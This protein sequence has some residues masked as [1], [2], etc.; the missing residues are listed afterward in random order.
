MGESWTGKF[1]VKNKLGDRFV[2]VLTNTPFYDDDGSL[3]GIIVVSSDS[4][5]FQDLGSPPTS[6]NMQAGTSE[7]R[8]RL[9]NKHDSDLQQPIQVAIASKI[10]KL[11]SIT[12]C[13]SINLKIVCP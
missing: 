2:V 7:P 9:M 3:V 6:T 10:T 11:V 5:S 1:P 4:R 13:I 8:I 12:C